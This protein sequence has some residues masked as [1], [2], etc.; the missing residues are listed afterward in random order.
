MQEDGVPLSLKLRHCLK[1]KETGVDNN[2]G[3]LVI[4][5][6]W[7]IYT[8]MFGLSGQ[9]ALYTLNIIVRC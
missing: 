6:V 8:T 2:D 3:S 5:S 9:P 1:E 7:Y 4:S